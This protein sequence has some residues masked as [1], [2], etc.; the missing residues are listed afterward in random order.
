MTKSLDRKSSIPLLLLSSVFH[1]RINRPLSDRRFRSPAY[2]LL[3]V[4]NGEGS[5]QIDSAR[6][7]IKPHMLICLL[8]GA[9]VELL[10][11][12]EQ[13]ELY[14]LFMET[15]N[16]LKRN[17][18]WETIENDDT[19]SM[20][21]LPCGE[22]RI[23]DSTACIERIKELYEARKMEGTNP[24]LIQSRFQEL[25]QSCIPDQPKRDGMETIG[26]GIEQSV[27]YIHDRYY[28]KIKLETLS[29][30]SGFTPTSYSREFKKVKG[31]SPIDYL[32]AYRI[33]QA[34]HLLVG[35]E[36]TIKEISTVTGFGS[37]FYFSRMF[38]RH[39]GIAPSHYMKRTKL[40]VAV[41][42]TLRFHETL[43]S[44]GTIP[45]FS[46][47]CHKDKTMDKA[48]H[49]AR[50]AI[51]LG[52]LRESAPD[53]IICDHY[54]LPFLERLK[55]IAPT[56][57]VSLSMDWRVNH[58]RLAAVVGK[59]SQGE[60]NLKLLERK[61][62][63]ARHRLR[64]RYAN[65]TVTVMRVIHQLIRIQGTTHHPLNDLIYSELGLKP[66]YC[67]P[68]NAMN[69]EFSPEKY[70]NMDTDHLFVQSQFFSPEDE[71]T[72][73]RITKSPE[74]NSIRAVNKDCVHLTP[75][76]VGMSWSPSGRMQIIDEL[77]Q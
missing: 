15:T 5:V 8:P 47:N 52:E 26:R 3:Y 39:V 7:P 51:R 19:G 48:T 27:E 64:E 35:K 57:A 49:E 63:Q 53:L 66:G 16:L 34:K 21:P 54:H 58:R 74:W 61:V 73:E 18:K 43:H 77:L 68:S 31:A 46:T 42:S 45:I 55:Q 30:I 76:W 69:V 1:R 62:N 32:N 40:K 4:T 23:K 28:E 67:V 65:E 13:L 2:M 24:F 60:K 17:G 29:E 25:I 14:L 12:S 36:R 9:A 75:N 10:Q 6:M 38:K 44:L 11:H 41:A 50:I 71:A 37:E 22:I 33:E 20:F 70:P 72:Y 56:V 59:E